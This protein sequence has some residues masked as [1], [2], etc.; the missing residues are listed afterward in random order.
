M[1]QR[2][3]RNANMIK[4]LHSCSKNDQKM[5]LKSAKPDLINAICDCLTNVVY[6]KIPIS[7]QMKTKLRRKKK[8][9]KELTDPKVTTVRKNLM[10][11]MIHQNLTR[12]MYLV[13]YLK[14]S[15][16]KLTRY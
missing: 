7:S 3:K 15:E 9:L 11:A 5:L 12:R 1:T 10:K 4:A 16:K 2:M 13:F 6:G 14:Q 8:V